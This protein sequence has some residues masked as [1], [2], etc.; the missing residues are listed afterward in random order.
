MSR[1]HR[2]AGT[3]AA[4]VTHAD[5]RIVVLDDVLPE[6]ALDELWNYF[7]VQEFRR[8]E[9]LGLFGH[10]ALDDAGALRGPAV[11]HGFDLETRY[12]SRTP[13]DL[14]LEAIVDHA[15]KFDAVLGKRGEGWELFSGFAQVY[16]RGVGL[17]WHR[18]SPDNAGSYTFYAHPEWNVDWGGELMLL[19]D[20]AI[21]PAA[22]IY[23]HRLRGASGSAWQPH[24]DNDDANELLMRHGVGRLVLPKPN[25]LVVIKGG[26]PHCVA[27]VRDAAGNH[28]RASVSGFFKRTSVTAKFS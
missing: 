5:E 14:V 24:L 20:D 6:A 10:W 23:F 19:D 26:T 12:P 18:D 1:R 2:R 7:Q 8:V 15:P 9:A 28:V 4:H 25:R 27:K 16:A 22:G 3:E 11:G 13:I 17:L 21:D